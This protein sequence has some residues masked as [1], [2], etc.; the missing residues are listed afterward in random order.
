MI[1]MDDYDDD[2]DD[3]GEDYD[4]NCDDDKDDDDDDDFDYGDKRIKK[5]TKPMGAQNPR[6]WILCKYQQPKTQYCF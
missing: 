6:R 4:D 1:T 3:D 5:C 2:D